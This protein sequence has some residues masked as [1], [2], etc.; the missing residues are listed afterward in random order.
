MKKQKKPKITMMMISGFD[1]CRKCIYFPDISVSTHDYYVDA[2]GVKHRDM[3][4]ICRYDLH[5]INL[6]NIQ[7]PRCHRE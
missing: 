5:E 1:Q 6:K 7:C 3:K 4:Y 2:Y